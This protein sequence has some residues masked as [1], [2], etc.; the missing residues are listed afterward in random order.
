M[1][2]K[3]DRDMGNFDLKQVFSFQTTYGFNALCVGTIFRQSGLNLIIG[4]EDGII[5]IFDLGKEKEFKNTQVIMET[6]SGPIQCMA[7]QDVTKFY[8]NDLIVADSCGMMTIFC[9]QQILCRQSVSDSC[10]NCVQTQTNSMNNLEIVMSNDSGEI[11]GVLPSKELWRININD[12][13][14]DQI[15][16]SSITCLLAVDL[17]DLHG[18]MTSYILAADSS[19]NL[20]VIHQG[21]IVSS[22]KTP[23]VVTAMCA[24]KFVDPS[25]L[26]LP[27]PSAGGSPDCHQVALGTESGAIYIFCNFS[28]T[29]E[30]YVNTGYTITLLKKLEI[31]DY[32]NDILVCTGHFNAIHIYLDGKKLCHHVTSDWV[33]CFDIIDQDGSK[34]LVVGCLDRSIQGYKIMI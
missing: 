23:S 5:R 32:D 3:N 1:K 12:A 26:S 25:K 24:G 29:E 34:E 30:E 7:V 19:C 18:K 6:K 28:I 11:F 10:I 20:S 13:S 15:V 14:K 2:L 21:L 33:N 22:V 4:G 16:K 27:P 9:N 8:H 31:P 17:P